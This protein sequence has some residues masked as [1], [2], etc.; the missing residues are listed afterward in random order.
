MM[1]PQF[2]LALSIASIAWELALAAAPSKA[3]VLKRCGQKY[4][5]LYISP[6]VPINFVAAPDV[7]GA[8]PSMLFS[9]GRNPPSPLAAGSA[10]FEL[11]NANGY[12]PWDLQLL[13]T[14]YQGVT[15]DVPE[16]YQNGYIE[17]DLLNMANA[18]DIDGAAV[19]QSL[20]SAQVSGNAPTKGWTEMYIP[21]NPNNGLSAN[22]FGD[23]SPYGV[24]DA[25][26]QHLHLFQAPSDKPTP[27]FIYAHAEMKDAANMPDPAAIAGNGFSI[28]SWET[29]NG[30][31]YG[32]NELQTCWND[33]ELVWFW[34]QD[35]AIEYNL[36]ASS[37][38]IGGSSR[39]TVCSWGTAHSEKDGVKGLYMV[40]ALPDQYW[41]QP[42][43]AKIFTD[44]VTVNSP[45]LMMMYSS[46]CG[47][48]IAEC[49]PD[50]N[51]GHN[52][53]FGQVIASKYSE[54]GIGPFAQLFTGLTNKDIG[55][56]DMFPRFVAT[57]SGNQGKVAAA[58]VRAS[59]AG[60]GNQ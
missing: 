42:A 29:V 48:N 37:V 21:Y 8:C 40:D 2:I 52:P 18:L 1:L 27:V 4:Y 15:M 13:L 10:P 55:L 46:E 26:R 33:F 7:S 22:E 38:I 30:V 19:M 11:S 59:A 32:Q 60:Q 23:N 45:P 36:D 56:W 50:P 31:Q 54:L 35:N 16:K 28:I 20:K 6:T 53:K 24:D 25:G 51:T 44:T 9:G 17:G 49:N 47:K 41:L 12:G 3:E 58:K 34:L 14:T 5:T 43:A 57:L 39:G